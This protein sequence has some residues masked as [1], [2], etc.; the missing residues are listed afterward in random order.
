MSGSWLSP[1]QYTPNDECAICLQSLGTTQA[2]FKTPC[3][4]IF[5]NDCLVT[6]CDTENG[7]PRCPICRR[8]LGYEMCLDVDCFKNACLGPNI[9]NSMP[10]HARQIYESQIQPAQGGKRKY[11]KHKTKKRKTRKNRKTRKYK[12]SYKKRK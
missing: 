5:H 9:I 6:L 3:N 4:H 10:S 2:I 7:E 8:E 11:R 1:N 12:K